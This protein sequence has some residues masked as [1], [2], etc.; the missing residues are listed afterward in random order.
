[1]KKL[2]LAS[3]I[4]AASTPTFAA[5]ISDD[6][7][8]NAYIYAYSMEEAYK[9]FYETAVKPDYP[10]NQF[11]NIRHLADDTYTAHPTINND[12]LHLMGWLDVAAEPVIVSV[13][14]MD[15]GRYWILHT[16]DMGHYT[17]SM[18]GS[19]TRDTKGGQFMYVSANW[20]GE[21]PDSV[22]EVVRVDSDI[23]KLMGRIMATGPED[24]KIAQDYMDQWNVRTLSQ[25]LGEK[26]PKQKVR[27]YPDPEKA[28]WLEVV[29]FVL[30]EGNLAE[31]DSKWLPQYKSM[32]LEACNYEFT[33]DQIAA[34][35]VGKDLGMKHIKELAP[36]VL[37][38][39][40]ILGTREGLGESARDWFAE[41][42]YIGQWG[43]P[44]V[45]AAYQ[46]DDYDA[47]G[48]VLNGSNGQEYTMKFKAPDVSEFWSLTVYGSDNRL[49]AHN[50]LNRHS[51]GDRT[52]T[53]DK[54]GYYTVKLSSD[55]KANKGDANFLPIP[56]KDFYLVM[57]LYGPSEEIQAGEYRMPKITPVK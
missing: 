13:P 55:T 43:L 24:S 33:Q 53:V 34:A 12:T 9:F 54:D 16:M 36:K 10:M 14:D 40:K 4:L 46:K 31:A 19:R 56:E 29:N 44:P 35:K 26:G 42:T 23:V 47:N 28:N 30:C 17:D 57:R 39:R 11:Q 25:Y 49:M 3:L 6:T 32:G 37:D 8:K 41:G 2:L 27:N 5:K 1:M 15:K 45:E 21:V 20:K 48:K 38:A 7:A 22:D 51:R 18:F 50:E 52:L